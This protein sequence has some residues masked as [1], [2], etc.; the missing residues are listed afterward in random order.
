MR[1]PIENKVIHLK[2]EVVDRA[3]PFAKS[4]GISLKKFVEQLIFYQT[5]AYKEV[6]K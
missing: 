5:S 1:K 4:K 6:K 3:R 2:K